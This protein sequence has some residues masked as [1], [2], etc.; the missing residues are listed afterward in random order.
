MA[1][2]KVGNIK[3]SDGRDG[4]NGTNGTDGITPTIGSNGNWFLGEEDTGKP[5][6]GAD[7]AKGDPGDKG[8]PGTPGMAV[9][10]G[11]PGSSVNAAVYLDRS[12]FDLYEN[13]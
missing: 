11:A 12:T 8:D 4:T 2:T 3:G 10:T 5:S 1:W 9:G 7:G 6:R 13:Q